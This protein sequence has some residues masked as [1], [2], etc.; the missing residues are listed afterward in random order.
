MH[1]SNKRSLSPRPPSSKV[2]KVG[3]TQPNLGKKDQLPKAASMQGKRKRSLSPKLS[4]SSASSEAPRT[5]YS[6][7]S[8][9][10]SK[11]P[12]T[13]CTQPVSLRMQ[14]YINRGVIPEGTLQPKGVLGPNPRA[15]KKQSVRKRDQVSLSKDGARTKRG[16]TALHHQGDPNGLSQQP[17]LGNSPGIAL[18][19]GDSSADFPANIPRPKEAVG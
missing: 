19:Q 18:V 7:S 17:L 16:K 14:E 6:T 1:C 10:S 11:K 4:S 5:L 15:P 8:A 3:K 2:S 9:S 13:L 12:A